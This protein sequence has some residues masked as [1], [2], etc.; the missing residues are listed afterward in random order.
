MFS[1]QPNKVHN[2]LALI[3][4]LHDKKLGLVIQY[5][6]KQGLFILQANMIKKGYCFHSFFEYKN[7]NSINGMK[8]A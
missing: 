5:V 8:N 1:F 4:N 2:M 6:G 7:L 3:L